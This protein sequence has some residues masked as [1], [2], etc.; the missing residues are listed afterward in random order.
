MKNSV[1]LILMFLSVFIN[2]FSQNGQNVRLISYIEF[3]TS[4]ETIGA[5]HNYAILSH[6]EFW[7]ISDPINPFMQS[8]I[9]VTYCSTIEPGKQDDII[10]FGGEMSCV[11]SIVDI[12][13][14]YFPDLLSTIDFYPDGGIYGIAEENDVLLLAINGGGLI[15]LNVSDKS[16]PIILDTLLLGGLTR[17]VVLKNGIAYV[18]HT[19]GLKTVDA[20]DS[21]NLQLIG[22]IGG[23][24][25]SLALHDSIVFAGTDGGGFIA[26]SIS[27]PLDPQPIYSGACGGGTTWDIKYK[28]GFV[29]LSTDG[30]RLFIYDLRNGHPEP[31]GSWNYGYEQGFGVS[32]S[33]SLIVCSG[34]DVPIMIMDTTLTRIRQIQSD[35]IQISMWPN[36]VSEKLFVLFSGL[37]EKSFLRFEIADVYNNKMIIK[38]REMDIKTPFEIDCSGLTGGIYFL[39]VFDNENITTIKK[40]IVM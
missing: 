4:Y 26:Y 15:S 38:P 7:D 40:F 18:A 13:N 33:D 5:I 21:S 22:S 31:F 19:T 11:F 2:S 16:N 1:L 24:F 36:P 17:D 37:K 6:G 12:S 30:I 29:Y 27:E 8:S 23:G 10:Y 25:W 39:K 34:N 9:Y 3:A 14:I 20:S 32:L 28:D 35:L